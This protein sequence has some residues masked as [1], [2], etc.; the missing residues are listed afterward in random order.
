ALAEV[1]PIAR[2]LYAPMALLEGGTGMGT[3]SV[4]G[5]SPLFSWARAIVRGAQER[6]KPSD[7]RLPEFADSRLSG[8]QSSL[9]AERPT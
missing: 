4:A 1:Q 8:V 9:F 7:Q 5:G 6:A 3:T 2:E